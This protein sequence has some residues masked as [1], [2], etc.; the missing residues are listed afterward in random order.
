VYQIYGLL[1]ESD[2]TF[3]VGYSGFNIKLDSIGIPFWDAYGLMRLD[4]EGNVKRH[5][6]FPIFFGG[7]DYYTGYLTRIGKSR[8]AFVNRTP[9]FHPGGLQWINCV[10]EDWNLLWQKSP[11]KNPE[12]MVNYIP[13]IT[14]NE[15]GNIVGCSDIIEKYKTTQVFEINPDGEV[16]MQRILPRPLWDQQIAGFTSFES[17]TLGH[18]GGYALAGIIRW[19]SSSYRPSWLLKIDSSG[20]LEPGC[21]FWQYMTGK[22]LSTAES[23]FSAVK[24]FPN[25]VDDH[26]MISVGN[27]SVYLI[28]YDLAS[29]RL[30]HSMEVSSLQQV[31]ISVKDWQAGVYAIHVRD[32]GGHLL[33]SHK[34]IVQHR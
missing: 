28:I 23:H 13:S 33:E 12:Y 24:V 29:G 16:V 25:P 27:K 19:E 5:K 7:G 9:P 15:K 3:L 22:P 31:Q 4:F 26:L 32:E 17:I 30:M 8:L 6:Y 1:N 10:D 14:T 2:S 21:E 20:C 18:D 34:L 11:T